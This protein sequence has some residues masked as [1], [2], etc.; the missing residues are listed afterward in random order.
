MMISNLL[1]LDTAQ[2]TN[3]MAFVR[4]LKPTFQ[5]PTE[6]QM[7]S[8]L[9]S[10]YKEQVKKLQQALGSPEHIVLSC[11]LWSSSPEDSYLTVSCHFVDDRGKLKSFMLKTTSMLGD[12]SAAS[13]KNHLSA[14]MEAWKIEEKVHG[15]VRA[16]LPQLK[17]IKT[18]WLHMPCF[19]D[20]LNVIFRDMRKNDK[21]SNILKKCQTIIR[22]FK[23][24]SDKEQRLQ[25]IKKCPDM[26]HG[27]LILYSGDQWLV[28]LNM[29]QQLQQQYPAMLMVFAESDRSDL[30]L[31][32]NEIKLINN[33]VSALLHLSKATSKMKTEGFDTI[34]LIVPIQEMLIKSLEKEQSNNNVAEILLSHCKKE[35]GDINESKLATSTFLDP[36]YKNQLG[37]ENKKLARKEIM[38]AKQDVP[39][40]KMTKVLDRYM[41]Y[42][43]TAKDSNPLSWWIHTGRDKFGE[44]SNLALQKLSI[45]STAVPLERAFCRAPDRFSTLRSSLEPE[46]LDMTLF[47]HSNWSDSS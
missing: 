40:A 10:V 3:F 38:K 19:A 33:I 44:L 14:V 39:P 9:H 21:L 36:R 15:V 16:G 5:I 1:S 31:S 8:L 35:F 13:I 47:L 22:F 34:A 37:E 28:W 23:N 4:A 2:N 41:A 7:N 24:N 43:P 11:E 20:T 25:E 17:G 32:E 42:K 46:N 29:L 30:N 12:D 45:V 26:R 18:S 27:K 6:P